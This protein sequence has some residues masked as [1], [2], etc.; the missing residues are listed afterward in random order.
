[1]IAVWSASVM[2][3]GEFSLKWAGTHLDNNNFLDTYYKVNYAKSAKET[4]ELLKH[5]NGM[6]ANIVFCDVSAQF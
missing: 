2:P 4:L 3:K 1:M 5:S 6:I